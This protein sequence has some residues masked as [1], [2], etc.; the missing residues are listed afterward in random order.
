MKQITNLKDA[1]LRISD[2]EKQIEGFKTHTKKKFYLGIQRQLD[3]LADEMLNPDFKVSMVSEYEQQGNKQVKIDNGF[4]GFFDIIVKGEVIVKAMKN[5]E[6][7]VFNKVDDSR[8]IVKEDGVE[9]FIKNTT[10]A[11]TT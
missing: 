9:Q 3:I 10:V 5:F 11:T 7:E 8:K 1:L 6:E 2:L 4:E